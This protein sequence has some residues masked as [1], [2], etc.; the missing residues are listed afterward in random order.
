MEKASVKDK[1]ISN[2]DAS[3]GVILP[4]R[5]TQRGLAS[6]H[7]QLMAIG[8]SIGTGL[9]VGIGSYLRDAGP[10]SLFLGYLVWGC[11]FILPVNLSVGEMCAYL[12]IRGSIFELAA[13]FIDPAFGFAMGWVYF[14][15]GVMLVCTEYAAVATVMQYWNTSVNPAVWVTMALVVCSCLNFVAVKYYGESEFIMASTKI[16]LLIGLVLL[17]FITMVGGNPKHD[18]Y[19]FRNWTHGVMFEYYTDG[20]TGRFLGFFSVMVYAAFSVAGP[21]LPALAA[22]EIQNPRHTIPRVVKMTFWRIVGFYVVGVLAVGIICSPRDPRLLSAIDDA[23]AGSAASPWVIGIQNLDIHGLPDLINLLILL[24]GWSCGNAYLYS[25]SRTLY[26]LARDGQAPKFLLKCTSSG[27]PIYCVLTVSLLSC[28]T[29]LVADTSSVTV[30]F[31]FVDLTTIAFVLT[32]TGM[33]C[34]FIAWYRALKAQGIDR[35]QF[36]PWAS[37]FQPYMTILAIVIGCLTALFNGFSVFKPF[38]IQ[39]FVTAYFGMA[40]WAV[41]FAFWK[42][43]HRTKFVSPADADLYSGKA[44]VDEECKIWEDGEWE[45]RRKVELAQMNWVRRVWEKMW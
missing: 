25:S 20:A 30:F 44:E 3:S 7:V 37:P 43:F 40:F 32:Y 17:T 8:G 26:S 24:S 34:V 5:E 29:F 12:P 33:L 41:M 10:L 28:I 38:N 9:F 6:R 45:E 23:A 1:P 21:D 42:L 39:G 27:I 18:V 11:L 16:L 15:G 31:W 2:E 14:Y 35:K 19:G 22:G 13:R 4:Y 36:V